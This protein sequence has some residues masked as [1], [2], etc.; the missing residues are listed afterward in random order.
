MNRVELEPE[1][2]DESYVCMFS[3]ATH[4]T[5][6]ELDYADEYQTPGPLAYEI[7]ID[8]HEAIRRLKNRRAQY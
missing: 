2:C 5:S 7:G 4:F 8:K 1:K 6:Y 3:G